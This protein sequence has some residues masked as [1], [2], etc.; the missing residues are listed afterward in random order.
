MVTRGGRIPPRRPIGRPP[1]GTTGGLK[2]RRPHALGRLCALAALLLAGAAQAV[3]FGSEVDRRTVAPGDFV[4][5]TVTLQGSFRQAPPIRPPVIDGVDVSSGGTSQSYS[6]VDFGTG[7]VEASIT[8]TFYLKVRTQRSFTIPAFTVEVDG[9]T[10]STQPIAIQV[11]A[12]ARGDRDEG[13]QQDDDQDA[14]AADDHARDES[15]GSESG[16]R[17]GDEIFITLQTD[18]ERVYLGE[19]VVLSFRFHRRVQ[20]WDSPQYSPPRTEGFW[21]EDMPPERSYMQMF[22]GQRYNVTEIRYALFPTR[23][24]RLV[25]EPAEVSVPVDVFE[26]FFSFRNRRERGPRQLRTRR[27]EVEVL[28]LP[29][30]APAGFSGLVA[31]S[32]NLDARLDRE[33]APRG[34]PVGLELVLTTDGFLQ[35]IDSLPLPEIA[36]ARMHDAGQNLT[37]DKSGERMLSRQTLSKVLIPAAEGELAVPPLAL[38]YFDPGTGRYQTVRTRPLGVRVTPSDLPVLGDEPES[39]VRAGIERLARD[40]AFIHPAPDGL[41]RRGV[42]LTALPLWW[43]ALAAPVLLLAGWHRWLRRREAEDR[44]PLRRRRRRALPEARR[45]LRR[46]GGLRDREEA[47]AGIA[48]AIRGYVADRRGRSAASLTGRDIV[49]HAAARGVEPAGERLA[50]L[51]AVCDGERFG[52]E[53]GARD[54]AGAAEVSR[55]AE[56]C[57]DLLTQLARADQRHE[58]RR[59]AEPG[60]GGPGPRTALWLVA[61]LSLAAA[62]T[63]APAQ[64]AASPG[65]D[66]VRLLAEGNQAYTAGD[67]DT[68][69]ALY[70]EAL[71]RGVHDAVL[72][73][74]LGNAYARQ[75]QLG[76]A[77]LSYLRAQRLAPRDAALRGNLE[78]VRSHTRDLELQE[79]GGSPVIAALLSFVQ[80]LSLDEWSLLLAALVWILCGTAAHARWRGGVSVAQRRILLTQAALL[81]IVAMIVG[82]RW[83]AEEGRRQGVVVADEVE[84]RSGPD[85]TFP[86]VFRV[87]DGLVLSVRDEREGWAQIGLGGAWVGW[88]PRASVATVRDDRRRS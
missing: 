18:R 30:P 5:L 7:Q 17:P 16:G 41:R 54:G 1:G 8:E 48:R 21:R 43:A 71:D 11:D 47:L 13:A 34:E 70:E 19:Q 37:V 35:G 86:V 75:G 12:T 33:Q 78:W 4:T 64:P 50:A 32:V 66:P 79:G 65:P 31:R 25:I 68:A 3:V 29:E 85:T 69:V 56:E 6:V 81:L 72:Y 38:T 74:N 20:L 15:I 40:L 83:L 61:V 52:R 63:D 84:V 80:R 10:Y 82:G 76:R 49:A 77:I 53:A 24:G 55:L 28:P 22:R 27:L 45:R 2:G 51:L 42:P 67:I 36:G 57:A 46:A 9:R 58:A 14:P 39:F 60:G 23:T 44:D 59:R 73:Y 88:V 62:T 87:H 26:R